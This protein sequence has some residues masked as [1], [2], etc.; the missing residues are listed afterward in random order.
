MK[1]ITLNTKK[2]C[3]LALSIMLAVCS[4]FFVASI[5]KKSVSADDNGFYM[6]TGAQVRLAIEEKDDSGIRFQAELTKAKWEELTVLSNDPVYFGMEIYPEGKPEL[7]KD[8]CDIVDS[9]DKASEFEKAVSFNAD[10]IFKYTA[11]ITYKYDQLVEE[12]TNSPTHNDNYVEGATTQEPISDEALTAYLNMAY[13]TELTARAYYKVDGVKTYVSNPQTRSMWGVASSAYNED[14]SA[15]DGETFLLDKYFKEKS[16]VETAIVVKEDGEILEAGSSLEIPNDATMYFAAAKSEKSTTVDEELLKGLE[17]QDKVGVCFITADGVLTIYTATYSP[18][19]M[20]EIN[21]AYTHYDATENI[22]YYRDDDGV[23]HVVGKNEGDKAYY[24]VGE[25]LEA[26]RYLLEK[27]SFDYGYADSVVYHNDTSTVDYSYDRVK[28]LNPKI[29]PVGWTS[30]PMVATITNRVDYENIYQDGVRIELTSGDIRYVFTRAVPATAIIDTGKELGEIFNQADKEYIVDGQPTQ[31]L[32]FTKCTTYG[33]ITK[34]VYMLADDIDALDT[35]NNGA[36]KF[37]FNNSAWNYFEGLF[38][39]RGYNIYNLDV[40]GTEEAPGNGLF[41]ALSAYTLVENVGFVNVTANYG[42]VF[43]GN[44]FDKYFACSNNTADRGSHYSENPTQPLYQATAEGVNVYKEQFGISAESPVTDMNNYLKSSYRVNYS[45]GLSKWK[46]VY[47]QINPE[48]VRFMGTISRNVPNNE[49]S[50]RG[51]LSGPALTAYDMMIEYYPTKLYDT[52]VNGEIVKGALPADYDYRL[53]GITDEDL[54][55]VVASADYSV[56]RVNTKIVRDDGY[57]VLFGSARQAYAH[58]TIAGTEAAPTA[59]HICDCY[60]CYDKDTEYLFYRKNDTGY[61]TAYQY[62]AFYVPGTNSFKDLTQSGSHGD[63]LM[64]KNSKQGSTP[65]IQVRS[66]VGLISSAIG[67]IYGMCHQVANCV[68]PTNAGNV[69]K[70]THT[71]FYSTPTETQKVKLHYTTAVLGWSERTC[72]IWQWDSIESY[73]KNEGFSATN[74]DG[75]AFYFHYTSATRYGPQF[76]LYEPIFDDEG[77]Y[78][79]QWKNQTGVHQYETA[80]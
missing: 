38:D 11:S 56:K 14:D 70:C 31:V 29:T 65:S 57:G 45:Q 7:A 20:V 34:G 59:D 44:L 50:R 37:T 17:S 18:R 78:Y 64:S 66:N 12:L 58:G 32:N 10:G 51:S 54:G 48:T 73:K 63:L 35:A 19:E 3:L 5:S 30:E 15:W 53:A 61:V 55:G 26:T 75:T 43:Q 13:G 67:Q 8:F 22:V 60:H 33:T 49:N 79:M 77:G 46:T 80:E 62:V 2:I 36:N 76:W 74:V 71:S 52:E 23:L 42:S 28:T 27:G 68:R 69:N 21:N 40:S 72:Y 25:G 6:T 41:S 39:G 1:K 4:V 16:E 47:V 9:L 24:V